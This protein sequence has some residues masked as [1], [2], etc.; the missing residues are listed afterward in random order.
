VTVSRAGHD[1]DVEYGTR[2]L[3]KSRHEGPHTEVLPT[4]SMLSMPNGGLVCQIN[5][6]VPVG[7]P[8][9]EL[10]VPHRPEGDHGNPAN[11]HADPNA[12]RDEW[13]FDRL[14]LFARM[15]DSLR[16]FHQ[17]AVPSSLQC[18]G[19]WRDLIEPQQ[20]EVPAAEVAADGRLTDIR[21][22]LYA[23]AH[24]KVMAD[25]LKQVVA[26][27][28][29]A[30]NISAVCQARVRWILFLVIMMTLA[31]AVC[32]H[33]FAHCHPR[34]V[35]HA[36]TAVAGHAAAPAE[37]TSKSRHHNEQLSRSQT[38]FGWWAL[39]FAVAALSAFAIQ[40]YLRFEERGYDARAIAEGLR[41]QFYWNL[42]GLGDS[43]AANY[44]SRHRSE[45]DWIRS[46][47]RA[48]SIPYHRWAEWFDELPV[49]LQRD[50]LKVI[51]WKWVKGQ[52]AYFRREWHRRHEQAHRWHIAASVLALAGVA[53][54][55][56][57]LLLSTNLLSEAAI[58]NGGIACLML[59][60]AFALFS[61]IMRLSA[62]DAAKF[63]KPITEFF[64]GKTPTP[65][66][67][68]EVKMD[69]DPAPVDDRSNG[70]YA[71]DTLRAIV[72]KAEN[73]T[74]SW[75]IL[76][77][78]QLI[79]LPVIRI[80]HSATEQTRTINHFKSGL[81]AFMVHIPIA[82]SVSYLVTL[83]CIYLSKLNTTGP[84]LVALEM[85][86]G[87]V[88][89]LGGAMCMAWA[90]KRLHSEFA[91][92]YNTMA[93]LFHAVDGRLQK[94][95]QDLDALIH[96][97]ADPAEVRKK[98]EHIQALLKELGQEALDE[99]AEWLLLHRARPLEPLLPG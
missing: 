31:A 66:P 51:H 67:T 29:H 52:F 71:W 43:V 49:S 1:L 14:R 28:T 18:Y 92:Q 72:H 6:S 82:I 47:V 54:F 57:L 48:A 53:T 42:A 40:R 65:R 3:V 81:A 69:L 76:R 13:I 84:D 94:E 39:G 44:M 98:I 86:A 25:H 73:L 23:N 5:L 15:G 62:D 78:L 46:V 33:I 34:H 68:G 75:T 35:E 96:R 17:T 59:T 8:R 38:V 70:R 26:P 41:I 58:R 89:L 4:T 55:L 77:I 45:L 16:R 22:L 63:F 2:G 93:G 61:L 30:E 20:K 74:I 79:N 88:L 87:G 32:L 7:Q 11:G 19:T 64:N 97:A 10:Q 95:L 24:G 37:V 90:E 50:T 21:Q 12:A 56:R 99:N 27:M 60:T 91:Y 85:T 36:E 83:A 9:L 80:G